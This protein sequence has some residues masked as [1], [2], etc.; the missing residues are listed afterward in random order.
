[1]NKKNLLFVLPLMF[2]TVGCVKTTSTA[3][4]TKT[5]TSATSTA[6]TAVSTTSTG[7]STGTSTQTSTGTSTSTAGD[8]STFIIEAECSPDIEDFSGP[9]FSGTGNSTDIII[10]DTDGSYGA[11]AGKFVSYLYASGCSLSYTFTSDKAVTGAKLV[12]RISGEFFPI[13]F[14]CTDCQVK[15]NGAI[16]LYSKVTM[17]DVPSQSSGKHKAFADY[18]VSTSAA[19][20]AGENTITYLTQ[21]TNAMGGTMVATAPLIDCFKISN[22]G[23]AKLTWTPTVY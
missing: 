12:W 22:F 14:S 8:D 4:S 6:S 13:S 10:N 1:M 3:T 5:S 17:D 15:L 18:T 9:G 7:A 2:L 16:Q 23:D 11:S 20:K 19:I 21:N